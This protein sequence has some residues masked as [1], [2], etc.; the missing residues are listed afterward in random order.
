MYHI[1]TKETLD[2]RS[3]F[4]EVISWQMQNS[5][6]HRAKIYLLQ[7]SKQSPGDIKGVRKHETTV[8]EI[9]YKQN[10]LV[11]KRWADADLELFPGYNKL[12]YWD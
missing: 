4:A 3:D 5:V 1:G 12:V 8:K 6:K 2:T 11:R 9:K 7:G 10:I